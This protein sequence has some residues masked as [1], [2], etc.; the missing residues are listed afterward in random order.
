MSLPLCARAPKPRAGARWQSKLRSCGYSKISSCSGAADRRQLAT[1]ALITFGYACGAPVFFPHVSRCFEIEHFKGRPRATTTFC[2]FPECA[3]AA[4][5]SQLA[6]RALNMFG[7]AYDAT[8]FLP[9]FLNDFQT[10]G[11]I[12][13]L[14]HKLPRARVLARRRLDRIDEGISLYIFHLIVW[15]CGCVWL[16]GRL[17][18]RALVWLCVCWLGARACGW[19]ACVHAWLYAWLRE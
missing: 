5:K 6:T 7:Y 10:I 17:H 15:L 8:L 14:R 4:V 9:R 18:V 13:G 11:K 19:A 3:G 12:F 2:K 16:F 1:R